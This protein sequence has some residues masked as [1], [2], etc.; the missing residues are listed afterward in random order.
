[1]IVT[2]PNVR[3]VGEGESVVLLH[4]SASSGR[5]WATLADRLG[6]RFRAHAVDLYGH[7]ATPAWTHER[8]MKVEDD[9]ALVEPLL[10]TAG[11][12]HLVGHSYGGAVAL[13][14]AA[15]FPHRVKSVA[16]YEPVLFRLLLDYRPRDRAA[17]DVLATAASLQRWLELGHAERSAQRFVDFWSGAG[18]WEALPEPHRQLVAARMPAVVAHFQALFGDSLDR[19]AVSELPMPVLCMTGADTPPVTRRIGELL[20]YALPNAEHSMLPGMGHMGPVTHAVEIADRIAGF[21]TELPSYSLLP[22]PL[23]QAA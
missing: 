12:V 2:K 13:K 15:L 23:K 8:P 14:I 3:S 20:R 5:Q 10:R 7:G 21:L 19:A 9:I 16:V 17:S 6:R 4:S 22:I 11:G 1:M 18:S